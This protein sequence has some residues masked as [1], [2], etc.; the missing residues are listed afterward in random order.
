MYG[1]FLSGSLGGHIYGADGIWQAATEEAAPIKMWEAFQWGSGAQMKHFR[2]FALAFGGR[3]QDLIPAT[4]YVLP[5]S[6]HLTRGFDGW[7]YCARTEGKDLFLIYFEKGID[8]AYLR[9]ALPLGTYSAKWF[10]PRSGEWSAAMALKANISG[11]VQ[12]PPPP[13][14]D[15]WALSMALSR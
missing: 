14:P 15:D 2:A 13:T 12:L 9:S 3:F 1:N 5:N 11:L 10:N 8:R 6:D 4:N 7:A